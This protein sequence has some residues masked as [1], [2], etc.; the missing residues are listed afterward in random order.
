MPLLGKHKQ[1]RLHVDPAELR[2]TARELEVGLYA[3]ENSHVCETNLSNELKF[4]VL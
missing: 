3:L 4:G 2:N 1:T